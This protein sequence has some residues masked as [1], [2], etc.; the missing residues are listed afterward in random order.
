MPGEAFMPILNEED[1]RRHDDGF[2]HVCIA[3]SG[4]FFS[5]VYGKDERHVATKYWRKANGTLRIL[6]S[7]LRK[8]VEFDFESKGRSIVFIQQADLRAEHK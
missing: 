8:P 5:R 4:C 1:N 2:R 6:S 3:A 7:N